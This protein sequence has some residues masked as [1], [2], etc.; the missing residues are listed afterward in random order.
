M[1]PQ[2][3]TPVHADNETAVG[4]VNGTIKRQRFRMFE[5]RYFYCCDQVDKMGTTIKGYINLLFFYV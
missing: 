2:P 4:I 1:H 3:P 5:M